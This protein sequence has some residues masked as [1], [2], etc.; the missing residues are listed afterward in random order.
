[1]TERINRILL[2]SGTFLCFIVLLYGCAAISKKAD[3]E[4]SLKKNALNYWKMR[5]EGKFEDTYKMEDM[6]TLLKGNSRGLPLNEYKEKAITLGI[7]SYGI[8]RIR[9]RDNRAMV[10]MVFTFISPQ[11]PRPFQQ[12]FTDEWILRDGKWLHLFPE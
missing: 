1:M 5:I 3:P 12:I 11:I 4:E 2:I 7:T 10:D 8:E 9:I 6:E